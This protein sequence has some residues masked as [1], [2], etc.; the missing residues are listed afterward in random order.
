MEP[1][2]I[3][4]LD[5]LAPQT[6]RVTVTTGDGRTVGVPMRPLTEGE[7]RAIRRGVKWPEPPLKE[8]TKSGPIYDRSATSYLQAIDDA[9]RELTVRILLACLQ[10]FIPGDTAEEQAAALS[11]KVG[12]RVFVQLV[13][14]LGQLNGIGQEELAAVARSFRAGRV[15]GAPGD[16]A[17]GATPGPV[18]GAPAG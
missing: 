16:G 17:A 12:Q 2:D 5:D 3:S 9:N 10:V 6:V 4:S 13:E 7:I 11:A 8:M 14:A 1:L 15:G 18:A